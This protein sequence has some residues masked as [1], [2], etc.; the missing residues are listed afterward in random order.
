MD[1]YATAAEPGPLNGNRSVVG[2]TSNFV[3][4]YSNWFIGGFALII[5]IVII[6]ILTKKTE[7]KKKS[8]RRRRN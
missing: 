8:R 5:V 3:T 2:G 7:K 4:E 1:P 6:A